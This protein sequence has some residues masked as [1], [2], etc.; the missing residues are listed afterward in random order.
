M[1]E[2]RPFPPSPRRR[3]LAR[4]AGLH[5]AS[6]LL[7][8]AIAA[9]AAIGAVAVFGRA[10]AT[11]LGAAI[12]S[13]CASADGS[14][15]PDVMPA[16]NLARD[17]LALALPILAAAALAAILAHLL[18][19]RAAWLPRRP[20][21]GAPSLP[22]GAAARG[23]RAALDLIAAATIGVVAFG[24]LWWA[25]PRL[26]ALSSI[27]IPLAAAALVISALAALAIAWT[28]LGAGDALL[29]HAA[30]GEALHMTA[31]EKR[32]DERQA[33]ADPRWR[34]LRARLA[35]SPARSPAARDATTAVARATLLVLGDD[36]AVAI[37][38]DPIRRPIPIR[39]ATGRGVRATQLL[40]LARRYRLP[41]HRDARLASRL[42]TTTPA[43]SASPIRAGAIDE[44]LWPQLAEIVAAVR[45]D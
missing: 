19:T 22:A 13:A 37:E 5:A 16:S 27:S 35:R 39:T 8:G 25:A 36:L 33:A 14:V 43:P 3:Q 24:W 30:V 2:R 42:V 18:Q 6:P 23:R 1:S 38:W 29:R 7:V 4:R 15:V 41:V 44:A 32:D 45:R 28:V 17:V 26:A 11:R 20:L 12:A 10:A 34:S 40:G 31:R 9:A 21:P